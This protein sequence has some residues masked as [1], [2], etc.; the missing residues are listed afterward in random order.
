MASIFTKIIQGEI[1]CELV[2]QTNSE[3]AFLDINPSSK[4]HTLVVPKCEVARLEELPAEDAAALMQTLQ[5]VARAVSRSLDNS[6]Y[7]IVLNN[8][9]NAGQE[10][11]HVH[12]H[13][14]PR[15]AGS[16]RPFRNKEAY[17]EGE[18]SRYGQQIRECLD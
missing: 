9:T 3:I 13:I 4:G 2:L 5:R 18:M 11:P 1:P 7:N 12:F 8:G 10:V 14:I 15:P 17:A 16:S 6:D